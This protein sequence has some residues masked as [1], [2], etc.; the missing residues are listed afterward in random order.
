MSKPLKKSDRKKAWAK[1][2]KPAS[3]IRRIAQNKTILIVC[4]GKQT[5][6]LYFEAFPVVG[7]DVYPKG[8][9]QTK[10]QLVQKTEK[11]QNIKKYDIV[12]CVFDMDFNPE[13]N[14]CEKDFDDAIKQA[15]K[16]GYDVAYSNDAFELWFYLHYKNIN[17]QVD[18]VFYYKELSKIFNVNNYEKECKGAKF[19]SYKTLKND[20]Y[21]SQEKAIKRA[22]EL[23]EMKKH[24][25][26]YKQNPVTTVYRL[27]ELLNKNLRQ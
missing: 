27:V 6:R 12:W 14:N 20:I 26:Y 24:L 17:N 22:K 7:L 11:I 23:H 9:G 5:E 21:S 25:P 15:K 13:I 3:Y 2:T 19:D 10:I 1:K 4:E 18:R 8:L 16:L